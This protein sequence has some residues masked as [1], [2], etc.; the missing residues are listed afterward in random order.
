M[1]ATSDNAFVERLWRSV[2]YKEV[3]LKAY[4]DIRGDRESQ[5]R[6]F[7]FYTM[8]RRHQSLDRQTPNQVYY[9]SVTRKAA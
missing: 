3:Y 8:E 1:G 2:K 4:D 7:D 6:Y 9:E 5:G